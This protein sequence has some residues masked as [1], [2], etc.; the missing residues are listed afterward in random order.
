MVAT[1]C[2]TSTDGSGKKD[3]SDRGELR[4]E[5]RVPV[6]VRASS[7]GHDG[8]TPLKD[9]IAVS[10]DADDDAA[11]LTISLKEMLTALYEMEDHFGERDDLIAT[12]GGFRAVASHA[13]LRTRRAYPIGLGKS[14]KLSWKSERKAAQLLPV[15][16]YTVA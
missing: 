5:F 2:P 3:T 4:F 11:H 13:T 10:V 16:R 12:I 14:C 8:N 9:D 6:R 15:E 1:G 7:Y